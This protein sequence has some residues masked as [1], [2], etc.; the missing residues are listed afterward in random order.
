MRINTWRRLRVVPS[1][2]GIRIL[3]LLNK[4][5]TS[6]HMK[7]SLGELFLLLKFYMPHTS[8]CF[9]L[10]SVPPNQDNSPEFPHAL[11]ILY[12]NLFGK[13]LLSPCVKK[14]KIQPF[15]THQ[16][17]L[18]NMLFQ[19]ANLPNYWQNHRHTWKRLSN[20]GILLYKTNPIQRQ[21]NLSSEEWK[22]PKYFKV[23]FTFKIAVRVLINSQPKKAP[24]LCYD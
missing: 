4:P 18:S 13:N 10:V 2:P 9:P 22:I 1:H 14:D 7:L 8:V 20:C 6:F 24:S 11:C 21:S 12:W 3:S 16:V 17:H 19:N 23:I 15:T 5:V